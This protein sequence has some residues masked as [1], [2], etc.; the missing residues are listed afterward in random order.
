VKA[1]PQPGAKH[2][3]GLTV[4]SIYARQHRLVRLSSRAQ[5]S[6]FSV[7]WLNART[8]YDYEHAS[9]GFPVD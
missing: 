3:N 1:L 5:I 8:T 9:R 2:L 4:S 7:P 6:T